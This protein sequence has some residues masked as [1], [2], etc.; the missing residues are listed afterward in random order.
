MY[1]LTEIMEQVL[2]MG[3]LF[4]LLIFRSGLSALPR[5][6]LLK[7]AFIAY[8]LSLFASIMEGFVYPETLN[9]I[10]HLCMLLSATLLAVWTILLCRKGQ[11]LK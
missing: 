10:E 2:A 6:M 1:H 5:V 7:C 4:S 9:H 8:S 11:T 3:I